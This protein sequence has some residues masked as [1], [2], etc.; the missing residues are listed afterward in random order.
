MVVLNLSTISLEQRT[1]MV[2]VSVMSAPVCMV[3]LQEENK[4]HHQRL[5]LKGCIFF[6]VTLL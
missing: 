6:H 4:K 1:K 5:C 3:Q 2:A